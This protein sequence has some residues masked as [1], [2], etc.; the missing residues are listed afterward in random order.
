MNRKWKITEMFPLFSTGFPRNSGEVF[1]KKS[2]FFTQK[3]HRQ[4]TEA[5]GLR[6]TI[7][8]LRTRRFRH[9]ASWAVGF[10]WV[11]NHVFVRSSFQLIKITWNAWRI[12]RFP[13]KILRFLEKLG[14]FPRNPGE[15]PRIY[16]EES[17]ILI[18]FQFCSLKK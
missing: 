7:Y 5:V 2:R 1:C 13:G 17:R 6:Q 16:G 11:K 4:L 15:T 18:L 8:Y 14:F 9:F 10:F 12:R 3:K